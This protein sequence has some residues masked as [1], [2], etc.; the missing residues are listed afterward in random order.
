MSKYSFFGKWILC[1]I[2]FQNFL[3]SPGH[4]K[5]SPNPEFLVLAGF[6][7][8]FQIRAGFRVQIKFFSRPKI[9]ESGRPARCRAVISTWIENY[10]MSKH[11]FVNISLVILISK[12][13]VAGNGSVHEIE[14]RQNEPGAQSSDN[15][16]A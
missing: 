6:W 13:F 4:K 10:I 5:P 1:L 7:T 12:F 9:L 11:V 3:I 14:K 2:L 16:W 8:E 15:I